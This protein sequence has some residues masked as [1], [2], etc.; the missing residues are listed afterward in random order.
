MKI[1]TEMEGTIR[2]WGVIEE[3]EQATLTK[4]D[5][6]SQQGQQRLSPLLLVMYASTIFLSAFLL[7][8]VQPLVSKAILPWYGGSAG[9]WTTCM[10]F[11]Q[12]LLFLGYAY[13]H[14]TTSRMSPR[15]QGIVHL[16]LLVAAV[17]LIR[18][19][20]ESDWK[21]IGDE[22]PIFS[23]LLLLAVHVGLPFF[24]LSTTSPLIQVWWVRA[25][26]SGTPYRLYSL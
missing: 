3:M 12:I 9:V 1:L 23:I 4:I 11:F 7:F 22:N 20:P 26:G 21:P 17:A 2:F 10:L 8:Q 18:V 15:M 14:F 25:V 5:S 6:E 19:R 24:L 16:L 13:A